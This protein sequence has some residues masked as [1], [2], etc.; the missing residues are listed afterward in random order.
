MLSF[1]PLQSIGFVKHK[2]VFE[3]PWRFMEVP[4]QI[5]ITTTSSIKI[6]VTDPT[7]FFGLLYCAQQDCQIKKQLTN[8]ASEKSNING[9]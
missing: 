9:D 3:F 6:V 8:S 2:Q 1:L 4:T 5:S 7:I